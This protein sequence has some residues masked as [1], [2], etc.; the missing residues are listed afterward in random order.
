MPGP[1]H[2]DGSGPRTKSYSHRGPSRSRPEWFLVDVRHAGVQIRLFDAR[3]PAD[4]DQTELAVVASSVMPPGALTVRVSAAE[5]TPNATCVPGFVV[6]AKVRDTCQLD[7]AGPV[8]F[9]AVF[10]SAP[11]PVPRTRRACRSG[12]DQR[13]RP[14]DRRGRGHHCELLAMPDRPPIVHPRRLVGGVNRPEPR[15]LWTS[16]AS[17]VRPVLAEVV[18]VVADRMSVPGNSL[19]KP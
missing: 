6:G 15:A 10:R 12:Q 1:D 18:G 13:T 16:T 17:R 7:R 4:L 14:Y 3:P 9:P 5:S 8:L 11:V 2:S 19:S